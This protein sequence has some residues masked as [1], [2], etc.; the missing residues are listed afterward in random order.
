MQNDPIQKGF[1][2]DGTEQASSQ[3]LTSRPGG[4]LGRRSFLKRVGLSGT[5][6]LPAGGVLTSKQIVRAAGFS[7]GLAR[8]DAAILRP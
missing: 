2:P 3:K 8:G 4:L 6:L 5:V 7:R 1:A